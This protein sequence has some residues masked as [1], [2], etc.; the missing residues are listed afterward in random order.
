MR[1]SVW[2]KGIMLAAV[3]LLMLAV[4]SAALAAQS[5]PYTTVTNDQVNLRRNASSTSTI[6]ASIPEGGSLTV[7]GLQGSYFKVTYNGRTGYVIKKYVVTD[8][9]AIVTPAPTA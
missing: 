4:C 6:L 1:K 5:Y 7:L 3:A 8:A 2:V 9:D